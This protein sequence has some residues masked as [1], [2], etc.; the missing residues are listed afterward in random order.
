M[1]SVISIHEEIRPEKPGV[2]Q[3]AE[4]PDVYRRRFE[5]QMSEE[6]VQSPQSL[7]CMWET[8]SRILCKCREERSHVVAVANCVEEDGM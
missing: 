6:F 3:D 5:I 4:K 7:S 1:F 8:E 2:G